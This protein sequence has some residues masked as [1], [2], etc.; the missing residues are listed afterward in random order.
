LSTPLHAQI[1][2]DRLSFSTNY[3]GVRIPNGFNQNQGEGVAW[4]AG[5]ELEISNYWSVHLYHY[6][7]YDGYQQLRVPVWGAPL[8]YYDSRVPWASRY[9]ESF[10][11]VR[12]YTESNYHSKSY[13]L[14][15]KDLYGFYFSMGW[16]AQSYKSRYWSAEQF[17]SQYVNDNGEIDYRTEHYI[18]RSE[19]FIIDR[20]IQ[21]GG[22]FKN[23]HSKMVYSDIMLLS[24]AYTRDYRYIESNVIPDS[25]R[26]ANGD[27]LNLDQA[28]AEELTMVWARNGRGLL[29]NVSIGINLDIRR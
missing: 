4:N 1:S 2:I 26:L 7:D 6:Q 27:P 29:L 14:R 25:R 3:N 22:G 12:L 19:V 11:M 21:F 23:F 8:S 16:S 5:F 10:G 9:T 17:L 20:G 24:S 18:D 15:N 13:D 28:N